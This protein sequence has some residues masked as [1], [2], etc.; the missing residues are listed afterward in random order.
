MNILHWPSSYPDPSRNQPFNCIFI[1]E[2]IRSLLP[3]TNNRVLFVS[4]ETTLS[5]K[6]HERNDTKENDIPITRFYFNKKLNL[7]FLNIYIRI[8]L[9][10]YFL[11]IIFI[12]KFRPNIL[13]IHFFTI[14]T[15]ALF[16]SKLFKIKVV[17]TEHWTALIG[18]PIISKKRF[19]DARNI[20]NY[21]S[22]I[23]PV[24]AHLKQGIIERTGALIDNKSSVINNSVDTS[25]FNFKPNNPNP[26]QLISVIRLDE[27]KDIPNM[28]KAFSIVYQNNKDLKLIIIGGGN[29]APFIE[30]AEE[31]KIGE[32]VNFAGALPKQKIAEL[33]NQ[34]GLFILSSISENSPCVIGEAH[35]CGLPVVATD[36]GGVN[37]LIIEGTVVPSKSSELLAQKIIEKMGKIIDNESLA[38]K[39]QARFSYVAIG[40]QINSVY[41]KVCAA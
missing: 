33:M 41:K 25:L 5:N 3:Y 13:H 11:E 26:Y 1:E 17:V 10:F 8:I 22:W 21:A 15:W 34:S 31:L 23:L 39:A 12:K 20:Y 14:G 2:H 24:S 18:Y 6:W 40:E 16:Y 28:L 29:A 7:Q 37:E 38:N 35:C 32:R 9:L 36:V 19:K 30:I 27:Q 4:P